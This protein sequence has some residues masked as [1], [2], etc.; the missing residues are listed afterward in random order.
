MGRVWRTEGYQYQKGR[1]WRKKSPRIPEGATTNRA[2]NNENVA[3]TYARTVSSLTASQAPN[4]SAIPTTWSPSQ[5]MRVYVSWL[6]TLGKGEA[7][8]DLYGFDDCLPVSAP[9]RETPTY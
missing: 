4:L 7:S 3:I 5:S 8:K 9:S 2:T 1:I 6:F